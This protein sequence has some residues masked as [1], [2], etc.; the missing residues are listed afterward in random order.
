MKVEGR[1]FTISNFLSF[2][3]ILIAWPIV[4]NLSL[5]TPTGNWQAFYWM[6]IGAATD[7]FDGYLAR[8]LNQK[9]DIGRIID[10]I[11]DKI[12]LAA[13]AFA[14]AAYSDLPLWFLGVVIG[15]DLVILILGVQMAATQERIPESNWYGKVAVTGI[16]VVVIFYALDVSGWKTA[17]LYITVSLLALS[18]VSYLKV[19]TQFLKQRQSS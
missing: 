6:L 16:G 3:R 9:S 11:A 15:R 12:A 19:Y 13:I 10:P 7:F 5:K 18:M 1:I 8:L 14:L 4:Y 17:A 2:A